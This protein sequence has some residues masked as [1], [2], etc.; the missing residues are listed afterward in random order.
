MAV[1]EKVQTRA[2]V[3][4]VKE[5]LEQGRWYEASHGGIG[6]TFPVYL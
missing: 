2:G 5:Q 4:F 1:L 6:S 3:L